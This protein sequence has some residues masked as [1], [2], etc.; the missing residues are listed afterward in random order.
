MNVHGTISMAG[1]AK[2]M[3][4]LEVFCHVSTAYAHCYRKTMEEKVYVDN[5]Q[6]R[7]EFWNMVINKDKNQ[8]FEDKKWPNPYTCS[9]AMAETYLLKHCQ[10]LP[11][12]IVRPSIV[13]ASW[14]EPL[15]GWIDNFN[16]PTGMVALIYFR[17]LRK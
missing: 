14:K 1:L 10:D 9:K 17:T 15:P 6:S 16:G 2:K 4:K 7:D 13:V 11:L 12:T 5:T 8:K 3:T